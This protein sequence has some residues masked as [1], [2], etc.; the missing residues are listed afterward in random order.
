M[1]VD[2]TNHPL[3][4]AIVGGIIGLV[5]KYIWDRYLSEQSRVTVVTCALRQEKCRQE[6]L[7]QLKEQVIAR[8]AESKKREEDEKCNEDAFTTLDQCITVIMMTQMKIC[9]KLQIDCGEITKVMV[10]KGILD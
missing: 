6:L 1:S 4:L 5:G 8:E 7:S 2:W 9:E 10:K 3:L